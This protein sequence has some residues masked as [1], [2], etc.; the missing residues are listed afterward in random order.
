MK[1]TYDEPPSN[2]AFT[3]NLR[4]YEKVWEE[5]MHFHGESG[6]GEG[7]AAGGG[8]AVEMMS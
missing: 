7:G 2:F 4:H 5:M 1:L 8:G 3:F 6:L